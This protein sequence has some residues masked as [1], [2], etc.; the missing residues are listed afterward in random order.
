MQSHYDLFETRYNNR[1][2]YIQENKVYLK[3][4]RDDDCIVSYLFITCL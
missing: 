1:P 4:E 2:D 3:L